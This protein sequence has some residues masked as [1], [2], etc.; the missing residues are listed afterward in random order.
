MESALVGSMVLRVAEEEVP[1]GR[2]SIAV[3]STELWVAEEEVPQGKK[4]RA[5][6]CRVGT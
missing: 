6:G 2:K 1:Q 4:S 5:V 3:G